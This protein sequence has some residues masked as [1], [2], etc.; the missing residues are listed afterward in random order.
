MTETP[1]LE[2]PPLFR[3]NLCKYGTKRFSNLE[4]HHNSIHGETVDAPIRPI[5][6]LQ[7]DNVVLERARKTREKRAYRSRTK[8]AR[9]E[10]L[11]MAANERMHLKN[12]KMVAEILEIAARVGTSRQDIEEAADNAP[13]PEELITH[14]QAK[15]S[16]KE[17]RP[18]VVLPSN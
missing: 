5:K 9:N 1:L 3:C 17:P 16:K 8:S 10:A 2:N 7:G 6:S 12:K 14:L 13:A 11:Q 15:N 18:A 4:R